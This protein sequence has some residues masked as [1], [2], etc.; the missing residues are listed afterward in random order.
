MSSSKPQNKVIKC[1]Q[2]APNVQIKL[3]PHFTK[4]SSKQHK[5]IW[6]TNNELE[7]I[8]GNFEMDLVL[9]EFIAAAKKQN[10]QKRSSVGSGR[11]SRSSS[12]SS[13]NSSSINSSPRGTSRRRE[14]GGDRRSS[15]LSRYSDNYS[16]DADSLRSPI[17]PAYYNKFKKVKRI[18]NYGRIL[19]IMGKDALLHH[20]DDE[21]EEECQSNKSSRSSTQR[22]SLS[23]PPMRG[24]NSPPSATVAPR[25][26]HLLSRTSGSLNVTKSK[27][28]VVT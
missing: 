27:V 25:P 2:F 4:Y 5:Q 20:D 13:S 18:S 17:S 26:N 23:L 19:N 24:P 15:V 21:L 12:S 14:G 9:K 3:V 11:S 8:R 1:V 7:E 10:N 16:S 6:Y 28:I 22:E